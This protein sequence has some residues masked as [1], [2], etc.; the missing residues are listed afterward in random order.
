MHRTFA[1]DIFLNIFSIAVT[2][3]ILYFIIMYLINNYPLI[4]LVMFIY[5]VM[6]ESRPVDAMNTVAVEDNRSSSLIQRN[7]G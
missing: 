4:I 2:L 5:V 1:E 7:A 6:E 3:Y